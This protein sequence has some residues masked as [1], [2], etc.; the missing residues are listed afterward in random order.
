MAPDSSTEGHASRSLL[1]P[2]SLHHYSGFLMSPPCLF[3]VLSPETTS[4]LTQCPQYP[5]AQGH[6]FVFNFIS[7]L[8][9]E[10]ISS[11][12]LRPMSVVLIRAPAISSL[13]NNANL[14]PCSYNLP[15]HRLCCGLLSRTPSSLAVYSLTLSPYPAP[16]MLWTSAAS[17]AE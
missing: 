14:T 5:L 4:A 1:L 17:P 11:T 16:S 10:G 9:V 8:S 13:G 2:A 6:M 7:L 15:N 12:R 3:S